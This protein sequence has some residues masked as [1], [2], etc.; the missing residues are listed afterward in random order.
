VSLGLTGFTIGFSDLLYQT[1]ILK[2]NALSGLILFAGI[3]L[4]QLQLLSR[5]LRGSALSGVIYGSYGALNCIR[6][7]I[8]KKLSERHIWHAK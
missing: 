5:D 4:G 6:I 3:Y 8:A 7:E 1:E 2:I